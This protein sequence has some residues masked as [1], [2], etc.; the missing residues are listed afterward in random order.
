M[1]GSAPPRRVV[2]GLLAG[3]AGW[4]GAGLASA[5]V[6]FD[7][8]QLPDRGLRDSLHYQLASKNPKQSCGGCTFFTAGQPAPCGTCTIFS[9]GPTTS[10]SVCDSWAPKS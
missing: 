3:G 2:L 8:A 10:A 6:C 7:L 4:A 1:I 9:G 5:Q